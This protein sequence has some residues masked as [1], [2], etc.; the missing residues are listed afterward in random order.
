[1]APLSTAPF[2]KIIDL[3]DATAITIIA[4]PPARPFALSSR[5]GRGKRPN[6]LDRF[7]E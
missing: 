7:L 6:P 5:P 3:G 2:S 1:V 4:A